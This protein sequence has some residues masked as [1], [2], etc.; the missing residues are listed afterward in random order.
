MYKHFQITIRSDAGLLWKPLSG[1]WS[2]LGKHYYNNYYMFLILYHRSSSAENSTPWQTAELAVKVWF[3]LGGRDWKKI[4]CSQTQSGLNLFLKGLKSLYMLSVF[5]KQSLSSSSSKH[6]QFEFD[7]RENNFP[8]EWLA[9]TLAI[10]I[11]GRLL[12]RFH[13]KWEF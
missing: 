8:H 3:Y 11:V 9:E 12:V 4:C 10:D 13:R 7:S 6:F 1:E 5:I 2:F